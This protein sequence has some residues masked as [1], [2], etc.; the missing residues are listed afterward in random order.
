MPKALAQTQPQWHTVFSF[1]PFKTAPRLLTTITALALLLLQAL[2][3]A[4]AQGPA[5]TPSAPTVSAKLTAQRVEIV[6]G[7][8]Q[9]KPATDGKPGQVIEYSGTYQN[10]G[11]AAVSKLLVTLPVPVGTTYVAGSADPALGAQASVDGA[12]FAPVPLM[13]RIRS[14]D[15]TERREP[16]PLADYRA[17]RWEISTLAP[18][19]STEVKIRVSIDAFASGKSSEADA[20]KM[21]NVVA[22]PSTAVPA[23]RSAAP[24]ASAKP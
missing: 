21:V 16:V 20:I 8:T 10:N 3:A 2:P 23:P 17:I 1:R 19:D 7:K 15:G 24:A 5:A 13:R 12:R 9:F 18:K 11:N 6:D 14:I 22:T 4:W